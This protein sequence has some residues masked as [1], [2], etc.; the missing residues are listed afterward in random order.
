MTWILIALVLVIAFGPVL[1]LV[2][3]KKDRRL[4]ALR[5]RAR[6]EGLVVDIRRL[7]KRDASAEER[8]SAGGRIREPVMECAAYGRM[9]SKKLRFL[10]GWRL[11]RRP[12]EG[13]PDPLPDWQYDLRPKGEG[14]A[15]LDAMLARAA[16]CLAHL[17]DDV[18]GL[19][20]DARSVQAYW[21]EKPGSTV[22]TVAK[23]AATLGDLETDL[24]TLD[25]QVA[26]RNRDT[27]S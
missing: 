12:A 20:V 21:L 16:G 6:Q 22:D 23:L 14:R 15:H 1:W 13:K 24:I 3:S 9:F 27:D 5:A 7:P 2:P 26:P 19:E 17:P 8:V 11:L 4:A 25:E 18:I 10:P